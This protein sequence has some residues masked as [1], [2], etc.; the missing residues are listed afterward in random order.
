MTALID[1]VIPAYD[2]HHVESSVLPGVPEELYPR[3]RHAEFR[4]G[5]ATRLLYRL[6]GLPD[7]PRS[8]DGMLEMGFVLV[9]ENPPHEF[10]IGLA[11]K[12]WTP[13][14]GAVEIKSEEFRDFSLDGHSIVVTNFSLETRGQGR[15][16]VS[17]ESRVRSNGAQAKL[18]MR[19]YWAVIYPFSKYIRREMLKSINTSGLPQDK[20][21]I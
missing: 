6:R 4:D 13:S 2:H 9:A 10:V 18:A 5:V 7:F 15:T 12:F 14:G 8:I 11:G 3:V 1:Q 17:T 16:R 20:S 19:A 21:P